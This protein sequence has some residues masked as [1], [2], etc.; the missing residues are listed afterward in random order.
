MTEHN[1]ILEILDMIERGTISSEEGM[2][3]IKA[4]EDSDEILED[5]YQAAKSELEGT[6]SDPIGETSYSDVDRAK[7]EEWRK[8]WIIPFGIGVG[9]TVLGAGL[10]YWGWSAAGFGLGF[11]LAWIPFLI[12]ISILVLGWNSQTGLWLHV[13]VDQKPGESPETIAISLPLPTHFTAWF[14]RTFGPIIP[15]FKASGL[16]EVILALAD[17][18]KQDAPLTIDVQD[19]EKEEQVRIYI[20]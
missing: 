2:K 16:D 17:R 14:L 5:E 8:W 12:G 6:G 13:R 10:M 1:E 15:G 18:S 20:G 7:L 19:D 11:F 9:I 3:L 4:I